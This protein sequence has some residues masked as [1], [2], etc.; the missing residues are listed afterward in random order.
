[1]PVLCE[2]EKTNTMFVLL[3]CCEMKGLIQNR[4]VDRESLLSLLIVNILSIHTTE[5]EAYCS[6]LHS[7]LIIMFR[8]GARQLVPGWV[9][10][11]G[12][13]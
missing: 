8:L 5:A 13:Q 9:P 1:M 12:N 3:K 6:V 11:L 10:I 7:Y 2:V 4:W